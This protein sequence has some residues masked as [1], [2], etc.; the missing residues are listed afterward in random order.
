MDLL[1]F[2][3]R[4]HEL[5]FLPAQRFLIWYSTLDKLPQPTLDEDTQEYAAR[6]VRNFRQTCPRR[7]SRR[8]VKRLRQ[9][10]TETIK[11]IVN[12]SLCTTP[13]SALPVTEIVISSGTKLYP[14]LGTGCEYSM[15]SADFAAKLQLQ[16]HSDPARST[17]TF[18]TVV[19]DR[20]IPRRLASLHFKFAKN[21]TFHHEVFHLVPRSGIFI[22]GYDFIQRF[23]PEVMV[24]DCSPNGLKHLAKYFEF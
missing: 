21:D 8:S 23:N 3:K 20:T 17:T 5:L 4:T 12:Q 10:L 9:L 18:S 6:T 22:F 7:R 24:R 11:P 13:D 2:L 14:I 15:M 1:T 19:E 16:I